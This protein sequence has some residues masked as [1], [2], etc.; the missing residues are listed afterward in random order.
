MP[1]ATFSGKLEIHFSPSTRV[2]PPMEAGSAMIRAVG[3]SGKRRKYDGGLTVSPSPCTRYAASTRSMVCCS[4][5]V[6]MRWT[7]E[8]GITANG[9]TS[10]SFVIQISIAAG[11]RSDSHPVTPRFMLLGGADSGLTPHWIPAEPAETGANWPYG[12]PH[13]RFS[14]IA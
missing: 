10:S 3:R 11:G 12:Q 5:P 8:P 9:G 7:C 1:A 6:R 2:S 14:A 13:L 4:W